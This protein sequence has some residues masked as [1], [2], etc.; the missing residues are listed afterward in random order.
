MNR[1]SRILRR[2]DGYSMIE[3]LTVLMLIAILTSMAAPAMERY[4]QH[5]KAR[6]ALD[7]IAIDISLARLTAVQRSQRTWLRVG[8]NGNYT[9]DTLSSNG[10][11][12][13]PMK[14][15]DLSQDIKGLTVVDGSAT[16]FEFSSRGLVANYGSEGDGGMLRI[17]AGTA[18]DSLFVSPTGR[19][20]RAF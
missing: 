17:V 9:I 10:V 12:P 18:R 3:L 7:R 14:T 6:R 15:V 1:S 19:V 2:E 11:D 13:V 20:Y 5:N 8:S 16:Q 4:I